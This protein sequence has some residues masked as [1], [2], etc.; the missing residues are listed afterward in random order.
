MPPITTCYGSTMFK[1][2]QK[3]YFWNVRCHLGYHSNE[4]NEP[5]R[6]LKLG[7]MTL[8]THHYYVSAQPSW[9]YLWSD[10]GRTKTGY[11][12]PK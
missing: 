5:I 10:G 8:S 12:T 2:D 1:L 11:K 9:I 3:C 7:H 6:N 4:Q